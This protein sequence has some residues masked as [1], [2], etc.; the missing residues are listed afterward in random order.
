MFRS[1]GKRCFAFRSSG[2]YPMFVLPPHKYSC[3]PRT[4]PWDKFVCSFISAMCIVMRYL[5]DETVSGMVP[6]W[7]HI[8]GKNFKPD[9]RTRTSL[10]C[11]FR[12]AVQHDRV[13]VARHF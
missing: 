2:V 10:P 5:F 7:A 1:L 13:I 11:G 6:K 8:A 12:L 4:V 9:R 3:N